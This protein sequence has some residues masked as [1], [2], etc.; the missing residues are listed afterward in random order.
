MSDVC[1]CVCLP[2][3]CTRRSEDWAAD[4]HHSSQRSVLNTNLNPGTPNVNADTFP[5]WAEIQA[6]S[7]LWTFELLESSLLIMKQSTCHCPDNDGRNLLISLFALGKPVKTLSW[8]SL[9][10]S[11]VLI[12]YRRTR[13]NSR[14]HISPW[15]Y[16]K[17]RNRRRNASGCLMGYFQEGSIS[18]TITSATERRAAALQHLGRRRGSFYL[19]AASVQVRTRRREETTHFCST[20]HLFLL[21]YNV[22]FL[23]SCCDLWSF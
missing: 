18:S 11:T 19:P 16:C 10:P 12:Q 13:P 21:L 15:G 20:F 1:R 5:H 2:G 3:E 23:I 14:S 8:T 7:Q 9:L 6:L 22:F 17:R 4:T